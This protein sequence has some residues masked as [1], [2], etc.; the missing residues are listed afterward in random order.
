MAGVIS[1]KGLR[2]PRGF[3]EKKLRKI[4]QRISKNEWVD[5]RWSNN[6]FP[7][8]PFTGRAKAT[9]V[10]VV[11]SFARGAEFCGDLDIVI[12]AETVFDSFAAPN[13]TVCNALAG[14]HPYARAYLG[15]PEK[16]DSYASFDDAVLLWSEDRPDWETAL[17]GIQINPNEGRQEREWDALPLRMEQVRISDPDELLEQK[18]AGIIDWQWID[19]EVLA[20]MPVVEE[21]I[22]R[23]R[24]EHIKAQRSSKFGECLDAL[25][26][27]LSQ[28]VPVWAWECYSAKDGVLPTGGY[29]VA[30]SAQPSLYATYLNSI[31]FHSLLIM[32]YKSK[33]GPNG[34]WLIKRG[35]NHPLSLMFNRITAYAKADVNGEFAFCDTGDANYPMQVVLSK[36]QKN[37]TT[38]V[39]GATL[40]SL[41]A[42]VWRVKLAN[43]PGE[44]FISKY[45][46][47]ED[48]KRL[49]G[50]IC[51]WA[52]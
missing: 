16:N 35:P 15:T 8:G 37:G 25:A 34:V 51:K 21:N 12:Q 26:R 42:A 49:L 10:W 11:G 9:T 41:L 48:E 7:G 31:S 47:S 52:A 32:P 24:L 14:A 28:D 17:A 23:R 19:W 36:T 30:I 13:K 44:F 45:I 20:R 43:T 27:L 38:P 50:K 1:D 29:A 39:T 46:D 2:Q 33:R 3:F 4:L 6:F 18:K 22:P 5:L 40:L